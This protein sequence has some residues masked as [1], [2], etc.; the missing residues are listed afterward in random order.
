MDESSGLTIRC[1]R[2]VDLIDSEHFVTEK[3]IL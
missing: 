3:A 1:T 2:C